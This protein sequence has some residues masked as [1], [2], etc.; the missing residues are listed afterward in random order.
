MD[1]R[2][3]IILKIINS[4][5]FSNITNEII[6]FKTTK[7]LFIFY[8]LIEKQRTINW[9]IFFETK[10]SILPPYYYQKHFFLEKVNKRGD[11]Q[12]RVLVFSNKVKYFIKNLSLCRMLL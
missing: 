5:D 1:Q 4:S 11:T 6:S 12:S 2:K 7:D 10:I 9:Q 3:Q 8:H